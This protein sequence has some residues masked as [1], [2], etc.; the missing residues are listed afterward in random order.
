MPEPNKEDTI[1]MQEL[2]ETF[3]RNAASLPADFACVAAL[4]VIVFTGLSLP[5]L[6]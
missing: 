3:T 6:F 1:E 5:S 2:K 4:V